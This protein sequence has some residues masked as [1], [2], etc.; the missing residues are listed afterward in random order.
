MPVT[1]DQ[2]TGEPLKTAARI[3]SALAIRATR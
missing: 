1:Y 3:A 2:V